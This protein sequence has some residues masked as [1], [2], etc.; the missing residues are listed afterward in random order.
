MIDN[1]EVI[2]VRLISFSI[3]I[4]FFFIVSMMSPLY[5][6]SASTDLNNLLNGLHTMKADFVEIIYDNH[7][8]EIQ[9]T[10]GQ[11]A[12]DRP[13]K[14]R[15]QVKKPIPQ[16][17]IA[18]QKRLWIYDPDLEQVTIRALSND[19][20]DAPALLLSHANIVSDKDYQVKMIKQ[21][22]QGWKYFELKPRRAD[23]MFLKIVMGFKGNQIVQMSLEDH[24]GHSTT[25]EFHNAI[26][27]TKLSTQTFNFKPPQ[28]IDIINETKT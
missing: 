19:S 14:F 11:I 18:N 25:I 21:N 26:F 4:F 8:K 7:G 22:V 23:S 13:G 15:W 27:N 3:Q 1:I 10:F 9:K 24:I 5:A 17:I 12:L 20:T 28:N 2:I 6:A 16:L